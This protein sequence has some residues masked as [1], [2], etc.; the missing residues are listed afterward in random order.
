MEQQDAPNP[1][2]QQEDYFAGYKK[3]IEA[4]R[5]DP[6]LIEFD[7]LC[8]ELFETNQQGKRFIELITERYLI[9]ALA[10]PGTATYQIDIIWSEGFKDFGR[11]LTMAVKTHIQ[12]IKSGQA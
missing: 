5:N 9:P 1:Y 3:H 4:L 8:Y 10:K 11:M 2:L 7:K 12:R 6:S